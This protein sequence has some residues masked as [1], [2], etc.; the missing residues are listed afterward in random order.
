MPPLVDGC[1]VR[2]LP[3]PRS[4]CDWEENHQ[5]PCVALLPVKVEMAGYL[6]LCC[7]NSGNGIQSFK[8]EIS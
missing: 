1:G 4:M 8:T 5:R 3:P 7:S 6:K 2:V